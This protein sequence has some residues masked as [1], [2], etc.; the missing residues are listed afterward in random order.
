MEDMI[1]YSILFY[2]LADTGTA[3]LMAVIIGIDSRASSVRVCAGL[4]YS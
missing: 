2:A 3:V 1:F 4:P